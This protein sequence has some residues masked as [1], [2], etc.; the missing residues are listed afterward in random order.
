MI[1]YFCR[2]LKENLLIYGEKT[3]DSY[4]ERI[5][6]LKDNKYEINE[7]NMKTRSSEPF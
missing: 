6:F 3:I 1:S 4:I 5:K 2:T 7:E